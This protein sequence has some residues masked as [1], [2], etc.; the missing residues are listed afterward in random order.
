MDALVD[1]S[2]TYTDT[3]CVTDLLDKF[4]EGLLLGCYLTLHLSD[5]VYGGLGFGLVLG[6]DWVE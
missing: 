5:Y 4:M 3:I 6:A 2:V 1:N